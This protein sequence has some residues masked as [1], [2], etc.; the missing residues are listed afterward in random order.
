M[1]NYTD[2]I[3]IILSSEEKIKELTETIHRLQGI[4]DQQQG[5]TETIERSVCR[6]LDQ[7]DAMF[8]QSGIMDAINRGL[9]NSK[10]VPLQV[11]NETTKEGEL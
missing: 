10:I 1:S 7:V 3:K 4:I 6:Y 11:G 9:F 2:A 5:S 8:M